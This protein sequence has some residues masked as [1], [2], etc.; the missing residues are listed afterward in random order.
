[1]KFLLKLINAPDFDG[2]TVAYVEISDKM[3]QRI[4]AL[5]R[6]IDEIAN[7][8]SINLDNWDATVFD[9]DDDMM[10]DLLGDRI[11]EFYGRM[12]HHGW[13]RLPDDFTPPEEWPNQGHLGVSELVICKQYFYWE[14][15]PP[16]DGPRFET[17]GLENR[18]IEASRSASCD[19][20]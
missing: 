12:Q 3:L 17:C 18:D 2:W 1:M 11:N 20:N 9:G 8:S 13:M 5:R 4:K 16:E 7:C 6:K 10:E 19:A 14:L 15:W